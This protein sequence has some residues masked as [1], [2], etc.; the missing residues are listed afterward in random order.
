M[1]RKPAK[2]LQEP[3]LEASPNK[4][5]LQHAES[6]DTSTKWLAETKPR[7]W[8]TVQKWLMGP[9]L[10]QVELNC[11]RWAQAED[12]LCNT[13]CPFPHP[14]FKQTPR[15]Q[16]FHLRHCWMVIRSFTKQPSKGLDNYSFRVIKLLKHS[17]SLGGSPVV[18]IFHG[19]ALGRTPGAVAIV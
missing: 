8:R 17:P 11:Y 5:V 9:Y 6:N 12:T 16:R 7:C 4:V 19:K 15:N 3:T 1:W 2:A 14:L 13:S 10:E 18:M